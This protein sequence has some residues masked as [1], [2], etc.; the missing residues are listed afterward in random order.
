VGIQYDKGQSSCMHF[1]SIT[2]AEWNKVPS[3]PSSAQRCSLLL[4]DDLIG[5]VGKRVRRFHH[6][7]MCFNLTF[8]KR[9]LLRRCG[10]ELD[11]LCKMQQ[12]HQCCLH[13]VQQWRPGLEDN[14]F[15]SRSMDAGRWLL[16]SSLTTSGED[17][18]ATDQIAW[19]R[20]Q[21]DEPQGFGSHNG[22]LH[23]FT[24]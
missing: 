8:T 23:R 20:Y 14:G 6:G 21:I 7:P 13:R 2:M 3:E 10:G 24:T 18:V 12:D 1:T 4:M 11:A 16:V 5:V 17:N 9:C 22:L 15:G 19:G